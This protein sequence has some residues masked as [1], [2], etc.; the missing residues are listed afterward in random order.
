MYVQSKGNL[1]LF[2]QIKLYN[3]NYNEIEVQG[4]YLPRKKKR[5]KKTILQ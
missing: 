3:L 2:E 1:I 5:K 4:Y